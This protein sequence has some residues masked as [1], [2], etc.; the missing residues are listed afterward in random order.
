MPLTL[1]TGICH[2]VSSFAMIEKDKVAI[3]DLDNNSILEEILK[4]EQVYSNENSRNKE[5]FNNYHLEEYTSR[6]GNKIFA[7]TANSKIDNYNELIETMA[8]CL[9]KENVQYLILYYPY[10]YQGFSDYHFLVNSDYTVFFSD[11]TFEAKLAM[12]NILSRQANGKYGMVLTK[13]EYVNFCITQAKE[14]LN[15][16]EI[17]LFG[18]I[19]YSLLFH[20][21]SIQKKV[22]LEFNDGALPELITALWEWIK[23]NKSSTVNEK[24]NNEILWL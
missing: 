17:Q 5:V 11:Y 1:G 10:E 22:V 20:L 19:P 16:C 18:E 3:L 23:S 7:K 12:K 24:M 2:F 6:F 13:P 9:S 4:S 21:A 14:E 15:E 8:S